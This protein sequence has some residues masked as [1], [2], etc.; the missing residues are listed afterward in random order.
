[1]AGSVTYSWRVYPEMRTLREGVRVAVGAHAQHGQLSAS[2]T[3]LSGSVWGHSVPETPAAAAASDP[4]PGGSQGLKSGDSR[5]G[6]LQKL[7]GDLVPFQLSEVTWIPQLLVFLLHQGCL[8]LC[9]SPVGMWLSPPPRSSP[10]FRDSCDHIGSTWVIQDNLPI[11]KPADNSPN[12]FWNLHSPCSRA[13]GEATGIL[14]GQ[15][16][17][18]GLCSPLPESLTEH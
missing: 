15:Y 8:S 10:T 1:M 6:V 11:L 13:C 3:G 2:G 4:K 18:E 14:G 5:A 7:R 17:S 16:F 12:S 9:L